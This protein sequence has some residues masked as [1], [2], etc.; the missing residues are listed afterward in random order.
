MFSIKILLLLSHSPEI[1]FCNLRISVNFFNSNNKNAATEWTPTAWLCH[2]TWI[3]PAT[4]TVPTTSSVP[5]PQKRTSP[6]TLVCHI[7]CHVNEGPWSCDMTCHVTPYHHVLRTR[8]HQHFREY[9]T[10]IVSW[11][12]PCQPFL[13]IVPCRQ[14]TWTVRF[15]DPINFGHMSP[16]RQ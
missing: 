3:N 15:H 5:C 4:T 8:K 9:D 10:L 16:A 12:L 14:A 7:R 13:N 2:I 11:I 1:L 6:A